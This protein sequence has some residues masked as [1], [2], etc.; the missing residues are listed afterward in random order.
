MVSSTGFTSISGVSMV[1]PWRFFTPRFPISG[2]AQLDRPKTHPWGK[3]PITEAICGRQ[4]MRSEIQ[5]PL[6]G[7][8]SGSYFVEPGILS[9][10]WKPRPGL[11]EDDVH[12][13][14]YLS[15]GLNR[16]KPTCSQDF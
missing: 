12:F 14:K 13:D 7:R 2:F 4:K 11:F 15:K 3:I 16:N 10:V 9:G 5:R 6:G 8:I 1:A